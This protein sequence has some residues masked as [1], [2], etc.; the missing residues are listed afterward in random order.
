MLKNPQTFHISNIGTIKH[1]LITIYCV[2][3]IKIVFQVSLICLYLILIHYITHIPNVHLRLVRL[4]YFHLQV[5]NFNFWF[6]YLIL[7]ARTNS[8]KHEISK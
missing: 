8:V 7:I 2:V 3:E 5:F 4:F 6:E 1:N